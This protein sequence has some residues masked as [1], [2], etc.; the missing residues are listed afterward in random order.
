MR[1]RGATPDDTAALAGIFY[2]AV[3]QAVAYTVDQRN[4]WAPHCPSSTDW[5]QRLKGL[6]TLVAVDPTPLG[7]VSLRMSDGYLDLAFV[8]P[9]HQGKGV[10]DGLH[11]A[12]ETQAR[13]PGL[14]RLHTQAS[15]VL[16]PILERKGWKTLRRNT[17][18][19]A[20]QDLRNVIMEKPLVKLE[21]T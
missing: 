10:F 11:T 6:V 7:F 4:A 18:K 13:A 2:H 14:V 20:G 9:A 1:V 3:Q 21:N 12:L 8:D 17:V 15:L 19:R 16:H 5:A